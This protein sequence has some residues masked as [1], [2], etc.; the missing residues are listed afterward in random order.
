MINYSILPEQGLMYCDVSGHLKLLD[1]SAYVQNLMS[2][3]NYNPK[4]KTIIKVKEGTTLNYSREA[5]DLRKFFLLYI[6]QRKGAAWAFVVPNKTTEEI[7]NLV[8][9]GVD[10]SP[11]NVGYFDNETAARSWLSDIG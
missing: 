3:E 10:L 2:D 1:I 9:D 7:T 4:L 6:Q 8:F 5:D 11:I